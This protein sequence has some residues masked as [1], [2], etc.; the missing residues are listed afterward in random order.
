MKTEGWSFG[1]A[2]YFCKLSLLLLLLY[3]SILVLAGFVAFTT[4]GYGM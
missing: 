4:V 2:V 1:M 3:I